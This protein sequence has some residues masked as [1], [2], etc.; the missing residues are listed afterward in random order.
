MVHCVACFHAMYMYIP[1]TLYGI[2]IISG[3]SADIRHCFEAGEVYPL[4]LLEHSIHTT[5]ER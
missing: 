1:S 4:G 2:A 5:E 3:H